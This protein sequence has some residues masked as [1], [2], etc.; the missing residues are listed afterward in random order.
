MKHLI[1]GNFSS[2]SEA[3]LMTK[4]SNDSTGMIDTTPENLS[5]RESK[6]RKDNHENSSLS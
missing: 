2:I 5:N 3:E 1:N 4:I 6:S